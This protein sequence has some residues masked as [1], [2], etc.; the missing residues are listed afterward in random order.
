MVKDDQVGRMFRRPSPFLIAVLLKVQIRYV[1]SPFQQDRLQSVGLIWQL[2][3][4][5]LL[6]ANMVRILILIFRACAE[7]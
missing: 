5:R 1:L 3:W 7:K 4:I 6:R 2:S